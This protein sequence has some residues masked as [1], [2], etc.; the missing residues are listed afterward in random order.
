MSFSVRDIDSVDL[1]TL[2][3]IVKLTQFQLD[4][5]A[6]IPRGTVADIERGRNR[7]PSHAIVTKLVRAFSRLGVE[8]LTGEH[9]FPVPPNSSEAVAS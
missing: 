3:L 9:L 1:R 4:D 6:Q 8:S 5:L 2:R 7:S